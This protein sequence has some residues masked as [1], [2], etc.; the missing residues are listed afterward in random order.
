M[1]YLTLQTVTRDNVRHPPNTELEL[2]DDTAARLLGGEKPAIRRLAPAAAPAKDPAPTLNAKAVI[3]LVKA[4]TDTTTLTELR[5]QELAREVGARATVIAA[6]DAREEELA[7][8]D[9]EDDA[10]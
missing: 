4:A 8:T 3:E 5:A 9:D 1:K 10:E 7:E 6:L 2:P